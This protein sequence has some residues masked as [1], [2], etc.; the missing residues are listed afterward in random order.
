MTRLKKLA[1][2]CLI[3][4]GVSV[5]T[6]AI[7]ASLWDVTFTAKSVREA[8]RI[9]NEESIFQ[10]DPDLFFAMQI[11]VGSTTTTQ[12]F[13]ENSPVSATNWDFLDQ[14]ISLSSVASPDS[15]PPLTLFRFWLFDDDPFLD[16]PDLLGVHAFRTNANRSIEELNNN[17]RS[18]SLPLP[19]IT[20]ERSGTVANFRLLYDVTFAPVPLP[21]ALWLLGT[22]LIALIGVARRNKRNVSAI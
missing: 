16:D 15:S 7:S 1:G 12:V 9:N 10:G 13:F 4:S 2:L 22:A 6:G 3:A 14:T 18:G 11:G 20:F 8:G 19:P 21:P 17:N 5:P